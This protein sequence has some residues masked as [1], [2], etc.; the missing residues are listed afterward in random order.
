MGLSIPQRQHITNPTGKCHLHILNLKHDV[1]E[2]GFCLRPQGEPTQNTPIDGVSLS[3]ATSNNTNG[4]YKANATQTNNDDNFG[5][6]AFGL[7]K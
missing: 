5:Y 1:S 4:V 2:T 7:P 3:P 6:E